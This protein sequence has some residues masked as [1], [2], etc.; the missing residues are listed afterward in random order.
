M[1]K[2]ASKKS[3]VK[4]SSKTKVSAKKSKQVGAITPV[5]LNEHDAHYLKLALKEAKRGRYTTSPNPAV[6]CVIVRDDKILGQG[7]HHAAG[8]P[9]AEVMALRD[10]DQ[11]VT[12]ATV[13]VTLEPCCH[14]G[15]TP[16]CALALIEA[17]VA[18]V[19]IG[20]RDPN[21]KVAGG[22]IAMLKEAGIDVTLAAGKL[23]ERCLKL[24]RAFFKSITTKRPFV[25]TK[26]GMSMDGKIA[27]SDGSSKWITNEDSRSDGQRLR[28]WSDVLITTA[29]TVRVDNPRYNVRIDELP[30]EVMTGLDTA[31]ITQPPKV[32]IDTQATLCQGYDD[33][34]LRPFSIF[35]QGESFIA[36]GTQ[37]DLGAIYEAW[38]ASQA[39]G[40]KLKLPEEQPASGWVVTP[41][42]IVAAGP[43][44][45]LE[46]FTERVSI[47]ALPQVG[48]HVSLEALLD[49]LGSK[50]MRVAMV[51]AGAALTSAF[52][53]QGLVDECYC[54]LAPMFL[55]ASAQS[56]LQ[57]PEPPTLK[58][59]QRFARMDCKVIGD[60]VLVVLSDPIK[61]KAKLKSKAKVPAKTTAPAAAAT[62]KAATK[63]A[64]K[65]VSKA[66]AKSA[67]KTAAK[68]ASK[69]T[70][71]VTKVTKS[72]AKTT[73]SAK[74]AT[75][76]A[77]QAA[78]PTETPA[79]EPQA[80]KS[81]NKPATKSAAK[82]TK[83]QAKVAP[84]EAPAKTKS[85]TKATGTKSKATDTKTS[86]KGAAA[87]GAKAAAPAAEPKAAQPAAQTA[88]LAAAKGRAR[89]KSAARTAAPA[90]DDADGRS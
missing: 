13:Y 90:A 74:S 54:Y 27:L 85:T 45:V 31:L 58:D 59:A 8:Q 43:N 40:T 86:K 51:E 22:G 56:G 4:A 77:A 66:A 89:R 71:L 21:P 72:A 55:G 84:T 76:A 48:A 69:A 57:L 11:D 64:T 17:K 19:V 1:S 47:L 73:K 9:H 33:K 87:K 83:A 81:A 53:N 15:R 63:A 16:P 2:S 82:R 44:F 28:L 42:R 18:R 46:R 79:V 68:T 88:A 34:L 52:L 37:Q 41:E 75:A 70:K 38:S 32:V 24:N 23:N 61:P 26:L 39:A 36:V 49:F 20:S 35:S 14:Y 7:F 6:G 10:A 12:G 5:E 29:A 78:A 50:E 60:N 3:D 30:A 25:I 80:T 67:A 65:A 62:T